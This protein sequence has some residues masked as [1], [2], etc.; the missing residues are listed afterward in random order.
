[1]RIPCFVAMS[2]GVGDFRFKEA[3]SP[4]LRLMHV[5]GRFVNERR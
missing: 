2:R 4:S 5:N 1:M 3:W